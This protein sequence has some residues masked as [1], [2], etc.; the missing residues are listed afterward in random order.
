MQKGD[1]L[2]ADLYLYVTM[3]PIV[4]HREPKDLQNYKSSGG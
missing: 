4:L 2:N 3:A 1:W